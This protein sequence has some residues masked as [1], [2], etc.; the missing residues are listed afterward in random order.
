MFHGAIEKNKSGSFFMDRGVE[1]KCFC[2][3]QLPAAI[4]KNI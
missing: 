4:T 3:V 2:I 1:G